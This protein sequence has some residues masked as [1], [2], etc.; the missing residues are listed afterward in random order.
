[1]TQ[2]SPDPLHA[3]RFSLIAS[4]TSHLEASDLS[5]AT[6]LLRSRARVGK[7]PGLRPRLWS[8]PAGRCG[9]RGP[10]CSGRILC[11]EGATQS[12]Q[13]VGRGDVMRACG[14]TGGR[15]EGPTSMN[16]EKACLFFIELFTN[17]LD[18]DNQ[19]TANLANETISDQKYT[20]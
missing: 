18:F 3:D 17:I 12:G 5:A 14:C 9:Y 1:M 10:D 7:V 4:S 6:I 11:A 2:L 16:R 8:R 13:D 19:K 15:A 20:I